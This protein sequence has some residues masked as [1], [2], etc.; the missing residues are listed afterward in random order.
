MWARHPQKPHKLCRA[1]ISESCGTI[2]LITSTSQ[3]T[4]DETAFNQLLCAFQPCVT[5]D[6]CDSSPNVHFWCA[7]VPW[8]KGLV[9]PGDTLRWGPLLHERVGWAMKGSVPGLGHACSCGQLT[10][11]VAALKLSST[12]FLGLQRHQE[13]TWGVGS[14]ADSPALGAAFVRGAHIVPG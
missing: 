8:V 3:V 10:Y 2:F 14:R 13:G 12:H 5:F 6:L 9:L 7:V 1:S 11:H 4:G